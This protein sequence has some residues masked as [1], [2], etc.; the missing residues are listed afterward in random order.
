MCNNCVLEILNGWAESA[1]TPG[2]LS[3][4]MQLELDEKKQYMDKY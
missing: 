2:E 1:L 4:F 3:K